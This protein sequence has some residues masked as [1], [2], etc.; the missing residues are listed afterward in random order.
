[1]KTEMEKYINNEKFIVLF[2]L[3]RLDL[4]RIERRT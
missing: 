4:I 2:S 1:M 3:L